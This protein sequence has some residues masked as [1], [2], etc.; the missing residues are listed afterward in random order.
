MQSIPMVTRPHQFSFIVV[1]QGL[2]TVIRTVKS[3]VTSLEE[4]SSPGNS[5][6]KA[7]LWARVIEVGGGGRERNEC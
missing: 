2:T 1:V 4:C 5:L 7:N 6:A 3:F